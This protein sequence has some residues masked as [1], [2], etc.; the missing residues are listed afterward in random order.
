MIA[1]FSIG[2]TITFEQALN[3]VQPPAP[4]NS[5]ISNSTDTN[6]GGSSNSTDTNDQETAPVQDDDD[7]NNQEE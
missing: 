6:D 7:I 4:A 5:T 3:I 2:S 1:M